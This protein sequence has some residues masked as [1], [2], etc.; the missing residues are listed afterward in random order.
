MGPMKI[1]VIGGTGFVGSNL[2]SFLL[3]QGHSVTALGTSPKLSKAQ[4]PHLRY[5]SADATQPGSWQ[6]ELAAS[7]AVVNLAGRTI[8]KRWTADYKRQIRDS[9]ILTT[10]HIVDALPVNSDCVLCSTSAVGYYGDR[11]DEILDETA[12]AGSGFL[13]DLAIEWEQEAAAAA[14]KGVRVALM[15]FGIVLGANGGA[16]A[17]MLPA[18]RMFAGGPLGDGRQWFPWIHLQDVLS[19]VQYLLET[20]SLSGPFNFSAPNPVR[21]R[22]LAATLGRVLSRPAFMPAPRTMLR[23]MLGE[24]AGSLVESQRAVPQNLLDSGFRFRFPE[25]D[26]ALQNIVDQPAGAG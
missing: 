7:D 8:F 3:E 25:I 23:L 15:R 14:A 10:R 19:A 4:H 16:M 12:A 9:R 24:V 6:Q 11:G 17:R 21:N 26:A 5:V 22:Q 2:C 1:T 20:P 13:A 18:F